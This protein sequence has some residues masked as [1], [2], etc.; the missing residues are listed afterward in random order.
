MTAKTILT[1]AQAHRKE[2][3]K[4]NYTALADAVRALVDERDALKAELTERDGDV[5]RLIVS[6]DDGQKCVG[7]WIAEHA[8]LNRETAVEIAALNVEVERLKVAPWSLTELQKDAEL[9]RAY[10]ARKDAVRSLVAERDALKSGRKATTEWLECPKCGIKSPFNM[11]EESLDAQ[12][13]RITETARHAIAL[14]DG[15][16]GVKE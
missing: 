11:G 2:P 16:M 4:A 15:V 8:K 9:W 7:Q 12:A 14:I 1:L 10:K 3:S 6:I 13:D 5:R